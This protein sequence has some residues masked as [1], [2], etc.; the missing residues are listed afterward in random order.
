M[1]DD[2]A[3]TARFA[4]SVT[5]GS[6][7]GMQRG[8]LPTIEQN[9]RDFLARSLR[10]N[11]ASETGKMMLDGL[12]RY[13][14]LKPRERAEDLAYKL[15]LDE[16]T[17]RLFSRYLGEGDMEVMEAHAYDGL[18][19]V[20]RDHPQVFE[21]AVQVIEREDQDDRFLT[22]I[23]WE[24]TPT[25]VYLDF[26]KRYSGGGWVVHCTNASMGSVIQDFRGVDQLDRLGLT[27]QLPAADR[28]APGFGFSFEVDR[29]HR[30][31]GRGG[32][33]CTYGNTLLLLKVP[34][35]L[36]AY[37]YGDEEH[38]AIF[39]GPDIEAGFEFRGSRG[40]W[41][42]EDQRYV[43]EDLEIEDPGEFETVAELLSWVEE[44]PEIY[45]EII[46]RNPK[47][48]ASKGGRERQPS[49]KGAANRKKRLSST[50]RKAMR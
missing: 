44:H 48:P 27:T 39:W 30:Y 50:M 23:P 46:V 47:P 45:E 17:I 41:E 20:R 6:L 11:P 2:H 3:P 8:R 25:W 19:E 22:Q 34:D 12:E 1:A 14:K 37:H 43:T 24:I 4:A 29:F 42:I 26:D 10:R 32:R 35:Y 7:G 21:R 9:V 18:E 49:R 16:A 31:S 5:C 36:V 28:A 13:L 33:T 15:F 40:A 38:Q